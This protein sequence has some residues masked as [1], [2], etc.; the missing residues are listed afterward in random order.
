MNRDPKSK[1]KNYWANLSLP[2]DSETQVQVSRTR[3][4]LAI[5]KSDWEK[6]YTF[7]LDK[8]LNKEYPKLNILDACGGNGLFAEQLIKLGHNVTIVD[9][10]TSLLESIKLKSSN[11]QV[12]PSDLIEYLLSTKQSFDSILFY[13]GIQYFSED[14]VV[15]ALREFIRILKKNGILYIGDIP[16]VD[17]RNNFL[18]EEKRYIKYFKLLEDG[19][20]QIGTWFKKEWFILLSEYLNYE[21]CE[22]VTQPSYQIYSD[23][24][25]DLILR[26]SK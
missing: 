12:I 9:I 14:E 4:G 2:P 13:A 1:W 20:S 10:N 16:D 23:F 6:T 3:N 22:I 26:K 5:N 8:L 7:V 25:F 24:R 18:K 11:L 15:I 21:S 17:C 19:I